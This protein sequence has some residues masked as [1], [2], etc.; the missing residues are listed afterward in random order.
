MA[1]ED[2]NP[3]LPLAVTASSLEQGYGGNRHRE[4]FELFSSPGSAVPECFIVRSIT[5]SI[6]YRWGFPPV[7]RRLMFMHMHHDH[8]LDLAQIWL[9]LSAITWFSRVTSRPPNESESRPVIVYDQ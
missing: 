6:V 2:R 7:S 4:N 3:R 9:G 5:T 8:G 1:A